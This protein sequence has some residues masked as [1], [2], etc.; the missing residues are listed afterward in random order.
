MKRPR[1]DIRVL[2]D[3]SSL[4]EP[5]VIF[6][7]SRTPPE[8]AARIVELSHSP[9]LRVISPSLLHTNLKKTSKE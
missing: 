3:R 6:L 1:E 5:I 7:R 9:R 8:V 4:G 2:I